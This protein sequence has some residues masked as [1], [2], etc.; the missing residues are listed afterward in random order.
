MKVVES[1]I[2]TQINMVVTFHDVIHRFLASRGTGTSIMDLNMAQKLASIY[3]EPL[4]LVF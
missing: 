4:L 2:D 3:Q 1:T